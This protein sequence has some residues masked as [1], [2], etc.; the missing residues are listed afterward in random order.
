MQKLLLYLSLGGKLFGGVA[1]LNAIPGLPPQY[2]PLIF[3]GASLLKDI[4][5]RAYEFL[6]A[7]SAPAQ[8]ASASSSSPS[9]KLGA[10]AAAALIP[11]L[12]LGLVGCSSTTGGLSPAPSAGGVSA[13]A[14]VTPKPTAQQNLL[15]FAETAQNIIQTINT[16]VQILAPQVTAAAQIAQLATND[17][18]KQAIL[19]KITQIS[20]AVS[21]QGVANGLPPNVVQGLVSAANTPAAAAAIVQQVQASAPV[22]SIPASPP[23]APAAAP[24][25]APGLAPPTTSNSA[26]SG[27]PFV[28]GNQTH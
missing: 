25:P 9:A 20:G 21:A 16:G 23:P 12:S 1:T 6:Q 14:P 18:K 7:Q 15:A 19:Q 22:A 11:C 28:S 27:M 4:C 10:L 3:F 8:G 24:A 2:G 17:P 26:Q 13:T 5:N